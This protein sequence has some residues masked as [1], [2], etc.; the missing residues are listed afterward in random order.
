MNTLTEQVTRLATPADIP[1]CV[2]LLQGLHAESL[3]APWPFDADYA[4]LWLLW[5]MRTDASQRVLVAE[6]N[7]E[8]IGLCGGAI[9]NHPLMPHVPYLQEWAL[10]VKPA[11]RNQGV[12]KDLWQ[13][14]C[15]LAT[16]RGAVLAAYG[17]RKGEKETIRWQRLGEH[18]VG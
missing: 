8:L 14:L 13:R 17:Q 1:A 3:W 7:G 12:A 15:L 16:H 2:E 18:Y 5:T 9:L 4:T 10:Y 11:H 6:Q